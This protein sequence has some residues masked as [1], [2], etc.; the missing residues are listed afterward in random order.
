MCHPLPTSSPRNYRR[1]T[2]APRRRPCICTSLLHPLASNQLPVKFASVFAMHAYIH[3]RAPLRHLV[4]AMIH[5][6]PTP[7]LGFLTLPSN[8]DLVAHLPVYHCCMPSSL[9]RIT[10]CTRALT[11]SQPLAA[12]PQAGKISCPNRSSAARL[13]LSAA[14]PSPKSSSHAYSYC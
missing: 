7:Q 2:H 14:P 6:R 13:F 9:R 3:K 1:H 10:K 8:D 5:F 4:V 11:L 12:V